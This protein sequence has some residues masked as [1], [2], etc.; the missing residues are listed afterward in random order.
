KRRLV[1]LAAWEMY[2]E[3]PW[4]GVGAGNYT[5]RYTPYADR[6]GSGA[7]EYDDPFGDSYP[8][9]L[10]LE[11]G[12][13]AGLVGLALLGAALALALAYAEGARRRLAAAGLALEATLAG[14]TAIALVGYLVS[15]LFLH[16]HFQRYLWLLLALAAACHEL[17]RRCVDAP[18]RPGAAGPH[19]TRERAAGCG[20]AAPGTSS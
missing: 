3:H 4:V 13:E 8:H 7:R 9:N 18:A 19:P 15:S 2:R 5:T 6:V 20:P 17:G 14:A 11:V 16:G 10:Y 1:T 12:A